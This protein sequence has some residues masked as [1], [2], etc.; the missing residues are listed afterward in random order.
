MK[1]EEGDM[2]VLVEEFFGEPFVG[3]LS[4]RRE[5]ELDHSGVDFGG[6]SSVD[7]RHNGTNGTRDWDSVVIEVGHFDKAWHDKAWLG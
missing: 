3:L 2:V 4:S 5:S 6:T 7:D 1:A